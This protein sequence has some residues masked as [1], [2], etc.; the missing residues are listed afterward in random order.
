MGFGLYIPTRN[1]CGHSSGLHVTWFEVVFHL[2]CWLSKPIV[3]SKPPY[4]VTSALVEVARQHPCW[5]H[6]DS[7]GQNLG[8]PW[9]LEW[10]WAHPGSLR[11]FREGPN[12]NLFFARILPSVSFSN[13]QLPEINNHERDSDWVGHISKYFSIHTTGCRVAQCMSLLVPP[14]YHV[15]MAPAQGFGAQVDFR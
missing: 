8:D 10:Y 9:S 1:D 14:R 6:F 5:I 4:F 3:D 13:C 7:L 11:D 15:Q 2:K 12:F